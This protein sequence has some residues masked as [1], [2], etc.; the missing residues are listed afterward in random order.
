M[1][2]TIATWTLALLATQA[3][4]QDSLIQTDTMP[5]KTLD[6]V[7]ITSLLIQVSMRPA[8]DVQG[9]YIFSGKKRR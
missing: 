6:S 4:A 7:Y 8:A 1:N 5:G 9:T 3:L 2:K